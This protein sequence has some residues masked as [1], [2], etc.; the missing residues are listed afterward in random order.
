MM[1]VTYIM[2]LLQDE[3]TSVVPTSSSSKMINFECPN[4]HKLLIVIYISINKLTNRPM[5]CVQLLYAESEDGNGGLNLALQ[6]NKASMLDEAIE[7]LKPLKM[8][9]QSEKKKK[10]GTSMLNPTAS[11]AAVAAQ[12]G[13]GLSVLGFNMSPVVVAG[14]AVDVSHLIILLNL[15]SILWPYVLDEAKGYVATRDRKCSFAGGRKSL[16]NVFKDRNCRHP[17]MAM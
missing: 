15:K 12:F 13:Q 9:V 3:G 10:V 16:P 11:A 7:Y 5:I 6:S 8:Q 14:Q 1:K 2:L 17:G 4:G